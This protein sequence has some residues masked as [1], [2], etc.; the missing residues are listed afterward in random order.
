MATA[1]GTRTHSRAGTT[2]VERTPSPTPVGPTQGV[3]MPR[4][5]RSALAIAV[6]ALGATALGACSAA[7]SGG[8]GA[9]G[10]TLTTG[11]FPGLLGGSWRIVPG[12]F[13]NYFVLT[14]HP[15][16]SCA[17]PAV[18]SDPITIFPG[19]PGAGAGVYC[20]G[21]YGPDATAE[22]QLGDAI[23][24]PQQFWYCNHPV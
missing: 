3:N 4:S 1:T 2:D 19:A 21:I 18:G 5:V 10:P 22:T 6:V 24:P 11:C 20:Q 17:V 16:P 12:G 8:G 14:A 15:D 23:V 7:P 9:P 13:S